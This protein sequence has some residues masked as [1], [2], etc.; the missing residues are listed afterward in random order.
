[1]NINIQGAALLHVTVPQH[2]VSMRVMVQV[3][4]AGLGS[5]LI[6][7]PVFCKQYFELS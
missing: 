5:S 1:M 4:S 6:H 2:N 7:F 3:A